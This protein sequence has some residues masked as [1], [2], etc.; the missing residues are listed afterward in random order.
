MAER[1]RLH[2]VT[3]LGDEVSVRGVLSGGY[4]GR[5]GGGAFRASNPTEN[6]RIS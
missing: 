5:M 2:A 3:L 6:C 1:H 4:R